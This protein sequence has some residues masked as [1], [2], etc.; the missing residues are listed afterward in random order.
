M[1]DMLGV[2]AAADSKTIRKAYLALA[3]KYHPDRNHG[4]LADDAAEQMRKFNEAW[5]I[6]GDP[7]RRAEY[8]KK[9]LFTAGARHE[10]RPGTA[11]GAGP[12]TSNRNWVPYD[13]SEPDG[14]DLDPRPVA[15][16]TMLPGWLTMAPAAG[17]A[18][19]I[20][21]MGSGTLVQSGGMFALGLIV[22]AL[23]GAGFLLLPLAA[24]SKAERDPNL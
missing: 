18:L 1:Y 24:M 14:I 16:S 22:M 6:L 17:I 10:G 23:A 5:H 8:D 19:G 7:E 20:V 15:G 4:V 21:I 12:V 13:T 11:P 3:W 9:L 2:N